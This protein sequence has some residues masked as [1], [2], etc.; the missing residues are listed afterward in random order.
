M[1]A[2]I[3]RPALGPPV[4]MTW[5]LSTPARPPP[6]R[7][8]HASDWLLLVL[9]S[10]LWGSATFF[11]KVAVRDIGPYTVVFVRVLL[12]AM[13]LYAV[14]RVRSCPLRVSWRDA[15]PFLLM[16]LF[17]SALPFT[18]IAWGVIHIDSGLA[19]ILLAT[20]PVFTVVLAHIATNDEKLSVAKAFGIGLGMAGVLLIMGG[21]VTSVSGGSGLAKLAILGAA[22]CYGVS[23]VYGRTL[24]DRPPL[25]LAWGQLCVSAVILAP[26]VVIQDQPWETATWSRDATTSII[27]LAVLGSAMRYLVFYRLL[28]TVGATNTS[29]VGFLIPASSL[30]L[31]FMVLDERLLAAQVAGVALIA[32]GLTVIDGRLFRHKWGVRNVRKSWPGKVARISAR[33]RGFTR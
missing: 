5:T 17:N 14:M 32:V 27:A 26:L 25:T 7:A 12:A 13:L 23:G 8:M 4:P 20:T 10:V 31:G 18:L 6:M 19:G 11:N 29:L 3:Q 9:L 15:K 1:F 16:G 30:L 21:H 2:N 33:P 22:L 28:A 24:R